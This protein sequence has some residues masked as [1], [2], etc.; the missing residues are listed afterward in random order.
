MFRA[1]MLRRVHDQWFGV[2]CRFVARLN[3]ELGRRKL[4]LIQGSDREGICGA[5]A[6]VERRF[7]RKPESRMHAC[8]SRRHAGAG[9]NHQPSTIARQAPPE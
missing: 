1:A 4:L 6:A 8:P 9:L 2:L 3:E 5:G 7:V